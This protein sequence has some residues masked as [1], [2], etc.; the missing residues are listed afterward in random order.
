MGD[1]DGANVKSSFYKYLGVNFAKRKRGK[2]PEEKTSEAS[3][4]V[5]FAGW[6]FRFRAAEADRTGRGLGAW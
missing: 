3:A 5:N 6:R 2:A 4:E 1:Y